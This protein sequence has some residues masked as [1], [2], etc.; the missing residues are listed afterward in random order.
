M[1]GNMIIKFCG[2][3]LSDVGQGE[4]GGIGVVGFC[5]LVVLV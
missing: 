1:L 4:G 3:K 2:S 5:Q